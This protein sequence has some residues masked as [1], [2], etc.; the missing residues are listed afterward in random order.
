MSIFMI[1]RKLDLGTNTSWFFDGHVMNLNGRQRIKFDCSRG[2]IFR[3][4]EE[5]TKKMKDLPAELLA[6]VGTKEVE[7]VEL[8][9]KGV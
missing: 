3:T 5:A 4:R 2:E 9:I 7:V 8:I 6:Q 1:R